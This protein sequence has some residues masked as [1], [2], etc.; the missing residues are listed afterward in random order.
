MFL[1]NGALSTLLKLM[2]V[3]VTLMMMMIPPI[4][5]TTSSSS[6]PSTTTLSP[7]SRNP[8]T[9]IS[10]SSSASSRTT[11]PSTKPTTTTTITE[12]YLQATTFT[13]ITLLPK[14]T[15]FECSDD[16]ICRA[17]F[18]PNTKCSRGTKTCE[19]SPETGLLL[20]P[21]S[22]TCKPSPSALICSSSSQCW[23]SPR[24]GWNSF[25]NGSTRRCSCSTGYRLITLNGGCSQLNCSYNS[26]CAEVWPNTQCNWFSGLC[27]CP[28]DCVT[29]PETHTCDCQQ[30]YSGGDKSEG[31]EF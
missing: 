27:R 24:Y 11:S 30:D 7:S 17:L 28:D 25:C 18:G 2:V 19:C 1:L 12:S 9:E 29:D 31:E 8:P 16:T 20:D 26:D 14:S 22:G 21:L 10:S 13:F 6:L 23:S 5:T 15:T 4:L 3:I